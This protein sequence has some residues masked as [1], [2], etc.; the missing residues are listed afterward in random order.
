MAPGKE[1]RRAREEGG[2]ELEITPLTQELGWR[3]RVQYE[4]R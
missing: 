2:K 4:T 3:I 1:L